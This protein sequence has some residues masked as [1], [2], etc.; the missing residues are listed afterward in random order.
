MKASKCLEKKKILHLLRL[1]LKL[2]QADPRRKGRSRTKHEDLFIAF[3]N[4][5][6]SE[7]PLTLAL[8]SRIISG[9]K[10]KRVQLNDV[11]KSFCVPAACY[12]PAIILVFRKGNFDGPNPSLPVARGHL[13]PE[14]CPDPWPKYQSRVGVGEPR[15]LREAYEA[16]HGT[17]VFS[18]SI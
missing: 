1:S 9:T 16:K 5:S 13:R 15:A 4:R 10:N 17:N 7:S 14:P 18:N 3:L 6:V 11:Y 8:C 2:N 12:L